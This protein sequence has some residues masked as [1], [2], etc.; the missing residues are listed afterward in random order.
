MGTLEY[1][2]KLGSQNSLITAQTDEKL[3]GE[4]E[5]FVGQI[6]DTTPFTI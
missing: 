5:K 3:G 2:M 4:E 6:G 1:H